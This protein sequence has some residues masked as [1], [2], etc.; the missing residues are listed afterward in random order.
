MVGKNTLNHQELPCEA[1]LAFA[2]QRLARRSLTGLRSRL[3]SEEPLH[4]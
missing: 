2:K 4:A 1:K 3:T